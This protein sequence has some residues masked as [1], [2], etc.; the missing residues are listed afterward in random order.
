MSQFIGTRNLLQCRSHHQKLELKYPTM[1]TL[2]EKEK[3]KYLVENFADLYRDQ[4]EVIKEIYDEGKACDTN[5]LEV[6]EGEPSSEKKEMGCQTAQESPQ[7]F[8][9][10]FND[11]GSLSNSIQLLFMN[12]FNGS[13]MFY[14]MPQTCQ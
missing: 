8:M 1:K 13:P 3:K 5:M 12:G 7:L 2:V 9:V 4:Y 11:Y 10:P 6:D 14:V